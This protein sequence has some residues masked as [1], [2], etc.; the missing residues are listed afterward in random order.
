LR[1]SSWNRFPHAGDNELLKALNEWFREYQTLNKVVDIP[2]F[3]VH[4]N[5][6]DQTGVVTSTLTRIQFTTATL[7]THS[8]W[9]A[10]TY[11]YT[12][13]VPGV[14]WFQLTGRYVTWVADAFCTMAIYL[15][16]SPVDAFRSM[17][18]TTT[19][20]SSN[21]SAVIQ[22]NGSTDYVEFYT[23]QDTGGNADLYGGV[24]NTFAH[25]FKVSDHG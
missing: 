10:S 2:S 20:P 1:L 19:S 4:R 13:K 7:D 14:Y 18:H 6:V 15:N 25:G 22:M 16:G 11:R 24:A 21:V 9:N 3:R 5:N 23:Q 8:F 12:P 17:S